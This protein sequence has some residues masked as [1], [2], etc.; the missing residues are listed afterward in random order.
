MHFCFP[1]TMRA[2]PVMSMH[3]EEKHQGHLDVEFLIGVS[4]NSLFLGSE[5]TPG[6]YLGFLLIPGKPRSVVILLD[7]GTFHDTLHEKV[8]VAVRHAATQHV[9]KSTRPHEILTEGRNVVTVATLSSTLGRIRLA[10]A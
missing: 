8:E 3:R 5:A 9:R 6:S 7:F 10:S 4:L 1:A 2:I